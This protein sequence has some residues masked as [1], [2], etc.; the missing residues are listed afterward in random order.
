MAEKWLLERAIFD[1][2][3]YPSVPCPCAF[4]RDPTGSDCRTM[5]AFRIEKGSTGSTSRGGLHAAMV[6]YAAG[7]LMKRIDKAGFILD[8]TASSAQGE[9]LLNIFGGEAGGFFGVLSK[10]VKTDLGVKYAKLRYINDGKSWSVHAGKM[11]EAKGRYR[12]GASRFG[13]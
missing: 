3:N 9:A 2:C 10:L 8:E 5:A 6:A 1:A 11:F 7:N 13:D 4:F 12:E